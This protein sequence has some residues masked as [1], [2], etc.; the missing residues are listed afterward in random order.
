[1]VSRAT[2]PSGLVVESVGRQEGAVGALDTASLARLLV[3]I[4]VQVVVMDVLR[5][6][7][8]VASVNSR[9]SAAVGHVVP[10]GLRLVGKHHVGTIVPL[11]PSPHLVGQMPDGLFIGT[12]MEPV[13]L[14]ALPVRG[15]SVD[16]TRELALESG[17][18]V[19]ELEGV[20]REVHPTRV[21]SEEAKSIAGPETVAG[22][23]RGNIRLSLVHV[24]SKIINVKLP[25]SL[26]TLGLKVLLEDG[27]PFLAS[28]AVVE[29][30]LSLSHV[31]LASGHRGGGLNVG[32]ELLVRLVVGV[33]ERSTIKVDDT[34]A[35]VQVG[36]GSSKSDLGAEAVTTE[37]SHSQLLLIHKANDIPLDV[38]HLE[39]L[40]MV[41]VAHVAVVDEPDVAHIKDLVVGP[42][43]E[44]SK[45]FD[46]L[47]EVSEPDERGHV[48]LSALKMNTSQL[49]GVGVLLSDSLCSCNLKLVK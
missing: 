21:S 34:S 47:N 24:G 45:V 2:S 32:L 43:E 23:P 10:A 40:V 7:L 39:A 27:R 37:S 12:L 26:A 11:E 17:D 19:V 35:S 22:A 31:E 15:P 48:R 18:D 42:V 4:S 33:I 8:T 16:V 14:R 36:N 5:G 20:G 29:E 1:M 44:R 3:D 13:V 6:G 38:V 9:V 30:L 41:R 46:G 25:V 49:D 28:N